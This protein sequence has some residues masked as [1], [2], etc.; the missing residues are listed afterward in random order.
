MDEGCGGAELLTVR[1]P[2]RE[3]GSCPSPGP[4][5][6]GLAD[7]SREAFSGWDLGHWVDSGTPVGT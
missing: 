2:G 6:G 1:G 7:G 4:G 5:A 3:L